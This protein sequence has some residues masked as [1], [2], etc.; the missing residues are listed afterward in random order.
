[1]LALLAATS[2]LTAFAHA[3]DAVVPSATFRVIGDGIPEPLTAQPADPARGRALIVAR[4]SANCVLCHAVPDATVRFAGDLGPSL[5][6]VGTRLTPAQ[7]RLRI[8]DNVRRDAR[9]VMPSYFK[10]D[11]FDRV[12]AQYRGK[13]I[14]SAIEIED[15]VVYLGTLR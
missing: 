1:M 10:V 11:G 9:T 4:E 15:I 7:L 3:A 2:M 8:A 5:A 13:P 12:A 14:L 6:G